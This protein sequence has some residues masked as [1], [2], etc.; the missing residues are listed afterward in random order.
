MEKKEIIKEAYSLGMMQ[1]EYEISSAFDFVK[2]LKIKNFLEIGTDQ[3][4]T[5]VVWSRISDQDGLKI[6]VDWAYGPWG[7]F[8]SD[9]DLDRRNT[10][11]RKMGHGVHILD[12][13]SHSESMVNQVKS[14]LGDDSETYIGIP[15]KKL[16]K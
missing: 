1:N 7:K 4:G 16:I 6:S 8:E 15:A 11:M 2:E 5:F 12:G 3:G 13:D 9:F 14:I 10:E